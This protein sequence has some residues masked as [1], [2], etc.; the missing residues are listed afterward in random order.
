MK[1]Y[2][3]YI[4]GV[5][6]AKVKVCGNRA[7]ID[8]KVSVTEKEPELNNIKCELT[9]FPLEEF[10]DI[11]ITKGEHF[12][13]DQIETEKYCFTRYKTYSDGIR[14]ADIWA[15]T[16]ASHGAF[17]I[18]VSDNRIVGAM[19]TTGQTTSYLIEHEYIDCTP[20]KEWKRFRKRGCGIG[21]AKFYYVLTEDGV[22]LGTRVWLPADRLEEQKLFVLLIRTCYDSAAAGYFE[23]AAA[24]RGYAV[25]VQDVR[26]RYTSTG[27]FIPGYY[28]KQDALS[29]LKW[30]KQQA[31]YGGKIG[32]IGA[33]YTGYTAW[34]ALALGDKDICAAVSLV[35]AGS[36][37]Y[38]DADRKNGAYSSICM[39][40]D[41]GMSERKSDPELET[42]DWD[43][44][45]GYLPIGDIP[46]QVTQRKARIWDTY[47]E[48]P[49]YDDFWKRIGLKQH[50]EQIDVPVLYLTGYHEGC[51]GGTMELW[52]MNQ[53]NKRQNQCLICGPWFHDF[54][55]SRRLP[56]A[57][58]SIDAVLYNP[59]ILYA[60][61]F[62]K[63]LQEED[64][65]HM[66]PVLSYIEGEN[67]W[68]EAKSLTAGTEEYKY[69]LGAMAC[70]S[71]TQNT[72]SGFDKYDYDPSDATPQ[73]FEE[74]EYMVAAD[75]SEVEKRE[76][77]LIYTDKALEASYILVGSPKV[78]LYVSSSAKDTDFV[79]RLT[80][81]LPEG[82]SLALSS[83]I[84]RAKY[85]D[86]FE[87]PTLLKPEEIC[88]LEFSL[89]WVHFL[90]NKEDK[91]RLE[92]CSAAKGEYFPNLNSGND[93]ATDTECITAHQKI[94][95]GGNTQSRITLHL[96]KL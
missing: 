65:I 51:I 66:P 72:E 31:W 2:E 49:D 81:V 60:R 53:K 68:E 62:G 9:G 36:P 75:Y 79:V 22:K 56:N 39:L 50:E 41:I 40:W 55:G 52:E 5:L 83:M 57:Q 38:G 18:V 45:F 8:W 67:R 61:W 94:Y 93:P 10:V 23:Q 30:I 63:W 86:S 33:S 20:L 82:P 74:G 64:E 47:L 87:K 58:L 80:R 14:S 28:E 85:R 13:Q 84:I 73:L 16:N 70:L 6:Y 92:I 69:F 78:V 25:V 12:I 24:D 59:D 90:L 76:D 95:Y 1:N 54:N 11:L 88:R 89:P 21:Q 4:S 34:A 29:T 19:F 37:F 71:K 26:G 15:D 32:V 27:E 44:A 42:A 96:R 17:D 48:H 46:E 3:Y 77:V 43:S 7:E 91:I 35:T